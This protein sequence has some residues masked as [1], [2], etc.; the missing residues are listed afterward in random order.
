MR[1][2]S[3]GIA[4]L[5]N[6]GKDDLKLL[7]L[8]PSYGRKKYED[9]DEKE[10]AVIDDFQGKEDYEKVMQNPSNYVIEASQLRPLL[11]G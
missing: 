11:T 1:N 4:R 3:F 10:R 2:N 7:W 6:G 9:M 8:P 5:G